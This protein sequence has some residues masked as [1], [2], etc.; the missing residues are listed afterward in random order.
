MVMVKLAEVF[1]ISIMHGKSACH[2]NDVI[3]IVMELSFM[4]L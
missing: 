1:S 4:L 3:W 2:V